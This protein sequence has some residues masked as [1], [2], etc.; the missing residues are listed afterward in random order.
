MEDSSDETYVIWSFE[1]QAE[2][3]MSAAEKRL[4]KRCATRREAEALVTHLRRDWG[5]RSMIGTGRG[6]L[7]GKDW[8]RERRA[9]SAW[10]CPVKRCR[11]IR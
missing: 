2:S 4:G 5:L 3:V 11:L 9:P 6:A 8:T 1:L 7:V 10:L